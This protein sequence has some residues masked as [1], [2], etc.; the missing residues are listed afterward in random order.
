M[1]LKIREMDNGKKLI[2]DLTNGRY[3][4]GVQLTDLNPT[5]II[6]EY[7]A[8]DYK[9]EEVINRFN[10]I[11]DILEDTSVRELEPLAEKFTSVKQ[12]IKIYNPSIKFLDIV[13]MYGYTEVSK[14]EVKSK[15]SIVHMIPKIDSYL[16]DDENDLIGYCDT[17][18]CEIKVFD[19]D[20][21][22]Y[23]K[24][25]RLFD[26]ISIKDVKSESRIYKDLSTMYIF[27]DP[28]KIDIVEKTLFISKTVEV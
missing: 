7:E 13:K 28:I 19:L 27:N 17:I 5:E 1:Y 10:I 15:R 22:T 11:S 16:S 18:L 23:Y 12:E 26:S 4:I 6:E 20:N 3:T 21:L 8:H 9:I 24:E 25:E 14:N 2:L